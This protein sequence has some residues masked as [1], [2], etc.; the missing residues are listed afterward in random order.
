MEQHKH[1]IFCGEVITNLPLES[2]C[3]SVLNTLPPD[4][5]GKRYHA[6]LGLLLK[7]DGKMCGSAL[8]GKETGQ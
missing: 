4:T 8:E 2:E 5:T 7:S 3:K 6:A 1:C